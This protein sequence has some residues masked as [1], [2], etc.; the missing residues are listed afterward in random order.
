[1]RVYTPL[2]ICVLAASTLGLLLASFAFAAIGL[3]FSAMTHHAI[4][5]VAA[6]VALL[7]MLW[8]IGSGSSADSLMNALSLFSI[9]THLH[10]FFQGFIGSGDIAYFVALIILFV[11]LTIIRLDYSRH[12]GR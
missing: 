8:L 2:D 10:G 11:G 7:F 5:A 9:P 3:F 4:I 6:S 1:M 12:A